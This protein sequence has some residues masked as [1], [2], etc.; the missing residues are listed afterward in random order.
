MWGASSDP[1][2][3]LISHVV[4]FSSPPKK[5]ILVAYVDFSTYFLRAPVSLFQYNSAAETLTFGTRSVSVMPRVSTIAD[6]RWWEPRSLLGRLL[7]P[8]L[9]S[10]LCWGLPA[11]RLGGSGGVSIPADGCGG[12][13]WSWTWSRF[14][15]M[16]LSSLTGLWM[17]AAVLP[18]KSHLPALPPACS[19]WAGGGVHMNRGT[20]CPNLMQLLGL[21]LAALLS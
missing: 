3:K 17:G 2:L 12:K 21:C 13:S 4:F 6:G 11:Q 7:P 18:H 15:N 9:C 20:C 5:G 14:L 1:P 8:A 16:A 19:R 10:P